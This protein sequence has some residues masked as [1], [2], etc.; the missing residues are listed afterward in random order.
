MYPDEKDSSGSKQKCSVAYE[1]NVHW[2]IA[3]SYFIKTLKE[4]IKKAE[5]LHSVHSR[6]DR[7]CM[8]IKKVLRN[9]L[10]YFQFSVFILLFG[11]KKKLKW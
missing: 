8:M 1:E 10:H 5:S 11:L 3:L 6:L 4:R 9:F 7:F 2:L